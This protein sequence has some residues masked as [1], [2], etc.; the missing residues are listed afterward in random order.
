M[1]LH[2]IPKRHWR[3]DIGGMVDIYL[4]VWSRNYARREPRRAA[5]LHLQT[6]QLHGIGAGSKK[7]LLITVYRISL[8]RNEVPHALV[9]SRASSTVQSI[10]GEVLPSESFSRPAD[11]CLG[12]Q[13][14]T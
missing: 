10:S 13:H 1:F 8:Q 5:I 11:S 4:S 9:G 14:E 6:M 7:R 2:L 12:P 3:Y